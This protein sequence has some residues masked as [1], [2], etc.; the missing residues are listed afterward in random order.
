M[1]IILIGFSGFVIIYKI[2]IRFGLGKYRMNRLIGFFIIN[3]LDKNP[4]N[5]LILNKKYTLNNPNDIIKIKTNLCRFSLLYRKYNTT[6]IV[7]GLK[8]TKAKTIGII[9]LF[10]LA[11]SN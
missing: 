2:I 7:V 11:D 5:L 4:N 9:K 8:Q 6:K 1:G 10:F 3:P